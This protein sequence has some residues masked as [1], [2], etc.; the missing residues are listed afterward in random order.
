MAS[1][2]KTTGGLAK[3]KLQQL[4]TRGLV[5]GAIWVLGILFLWDTMM[6]AFAEGMGQPG[7]YYAGFLVV[8]LIIGL[9]V[10]LWRDPHG[11]RSGGTDSIPVG[12]NNSKAD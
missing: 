9:A 7:M 11:I 5:L 12:T 3:E 2:W 10:Y 1:F 4:G 8:W 6:G